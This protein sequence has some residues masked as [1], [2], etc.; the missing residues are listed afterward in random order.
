MMP[1]DLSGLPTRGPTGERDNLERLLLVLGATM[2]RQ[3]V[4][5]M[6]VRHNDGCPCAADDRPMGDCICETV[7]VTIEAV[8]P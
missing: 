7:D 2:P 6:Q 4:A 1:L 5:V 3:L 8:R